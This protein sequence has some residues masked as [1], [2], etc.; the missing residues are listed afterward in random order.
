MLAMLDAMEI[1]YVIIDNDEDVTKSQINQAMTYVTEKSAPYALVI[2]KNTFSK[3]DYEGAEGQSNFMREAAVETISHFF[4][5]DTVFIAT[6][7]MTAR[8]LFEVR[9][10]TDQSHE[11]D[12]LVIGGMGHASQIA[13]GVSLNTPTKNVVCMDGDGALLMHMGSLGLNGT[14]G[15]DNFIHIVLNNGAHESV[16]AQKTLTPHICLTDLATAC[17]YRSVQQASSPESLKAALAQITHTTGP[18][19]IEVA[20]ACGHRNDLGRPTMSPAQNKISV[21]EYLEMTN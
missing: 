19:F 14:Y 18:H 15:K 7:G 4:T 20:T 9:D 21:Q 8:E 11:K 5:D 6:T 2:R 13:L 12:F 1:P 10:K 3:Y 16:G 17:G